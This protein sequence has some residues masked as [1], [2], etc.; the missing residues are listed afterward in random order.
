MIILCFVSILRPPISTR[1]DTL[2]PY[3]TL[4]RSRVDAHVA[5]GFQQIDLGAGLFVPARVAVVG[6]QHIRQHLDVT[7]GGARIAARAVGLVVTVP[8]AAVVGID[9]QRLVAL[10]PA[11]DRFPVPAG[12][13]QTR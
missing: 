7:A 8:L 4:F 10:W 11:P 6:G 9:L 3:S 2:F 13:Q 1:T 5:H 12:G